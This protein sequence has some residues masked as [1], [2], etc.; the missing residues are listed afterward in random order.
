M[1]LRYAALAALLACSA[2]AY[3]SR[4]ACPCESDRVAMRDFR[5]R[6]AAAESP[7][8]AREL[9]LDQTRLGHKA[10]SRVAK[11]LPNN[12]EL[13]EADARLTTFEANIGAATTQ[14]EVA[15]QFDQ[16]MATPTGATNCAYT[17]T[18]V[19]IV[20]IGFLLGILPGI[21]FLFL[22]LFC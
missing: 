11:A 18:E 21:L 17:P 9:A 3:A 14:A 15:N 8:A 4:P 12:P 5:D 2:P 20:V 7:E 10:I 13:V 1:V 22:F 19:L 6:I 16:L